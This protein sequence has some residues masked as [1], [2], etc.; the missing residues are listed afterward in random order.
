MTEA[1]GR[2]ILREGHN[3]ATIARADKLAV[4]VDASDYFRH[5]RSAILQA[6]RHVLLIGWDFD[7]RIKMVPG[8]KTEGP[9][10]VGRFLNW[11]IRRRPDLHVRILKWDLGVIQALGR[12]STPIFILDWMTSH[13]IKFKLDSAH[14][15]GAAHHQKIAIVDDVLA[16][17]GGIDLTADRWDTREHRDKEPRRRRP[18]TRRHYGPWHD[19][20][21]CVTGPVAAAM[22][23]VARHRWKRA[24]GEDLAPPPPCDPVWPE[25]LSPSMENV[26]VAISRSMPEYDGDAGVYEIEALYLDAI[27]AAKDR[28]YIESQYFASRKI[29]EAMATRL[30]E[31]DGPEIVLVNPKTAQGWLEE[32]VMGASRVQLLRLIREADVYNRFR[33]YHPV[34]EGGTPIYVHA[35]V[36]VVDETFLRV[37]SSNLNNRSMGYDTEC[38]LSV[39]ATDKTTANRIAAVRNDLLAEHLGTTEERVAETIAARS[40]LIAAIEDLRSTGR[41]LEPIEPP[42][43]NIVEEQVLAENDWLDPE[44]ATP[45]RLQR[46]WRKLLSFTNARAT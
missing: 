13:R 45:T 7:S 46:V 18:T 28:I 14:P 1:T 6:K 30:A 40:S 19:A 4:I 36:L 22:A 29:A 5:L 8:E 39:E 26:D 32:E 33:I 11:I 23:D 10:R 9:N 2:R 15:L 24:T 12:G 20:S 17:C 16:F 21:T 43:L 38:D 27:A 37:G 3:C 42:E 31:P 41:S 34:T 35:K 25:G 44:R